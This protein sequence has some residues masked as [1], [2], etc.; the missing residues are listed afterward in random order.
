MLF[1][2]LLS[3]FLDFSFPFPSSPSLQWIYSESPWFCCIVFFS[4]SLYFFLFLLFDS[5]WALFLSDLILCLPSF[6]QGLTEELVYNYKTPDWR[7]FPCLN[8]QMHHW[9]THGSN[10][11]LKQ[12]QW[13]PQSLVSDNYCWAWTTC[14]A[15]SEAT[16][17]HLQAT[18]AHPRRASSNASQGQSQT[19]R[20]TTGS[21]LSSTLTRV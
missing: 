6:E 21:T 10:L 12:G 15:G 5:R 11:T 14:A 17:E 16:A 2:S 7:G 1:I 19:V 3:N 18:S 13:G 4:P 8:P 9:P 20:V